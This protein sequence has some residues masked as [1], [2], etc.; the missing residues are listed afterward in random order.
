[1]PALPVSADPLRMR[2]LTKDAE[3]SMCIDVCMGS[4]FLS[5]KI[6][7]WIVAQHEAREGGGIRAR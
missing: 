7:L 6:F 3:D 4:D 5:S 2:F 1:M